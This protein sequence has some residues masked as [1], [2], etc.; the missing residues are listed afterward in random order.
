LSLSMA[1][2]PRLELEFEFCLAIVIPPSDF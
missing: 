2:K 1:A